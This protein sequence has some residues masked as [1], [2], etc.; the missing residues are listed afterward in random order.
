MGLNSSLQIGRS[1]L[2]VSQVA[3]QVTGNNFANASTPGYSRQ[4]V[5]LAPNI[6][7]RQGGYFLG[8]GVGIQGITR[9]V[10][11]ALQA[12][13][14]S[15]LSQE[16]FAATVSQMLSNVESTLNE[17]TDND[18]SSEFG[19]FF[20]AWSQLA[21][22]PDQGGRRSIVIQQ[23]RT[24]AASI[25]SL[26]S[27]LTQLRTQ[28]DNQLSATVQTADSLLSRIA[29]LNA[30][31][32]NAEGGSST[33]N[34]LRD[35]RD[36]LVQELSRLMDVSTVEQPSGTL[37]VLVGSTPVVL[38]GVSRG[39]E[40]QRQ[41]VNGEVRVS[42]NLKSDSTRLDVASGSIGGLLDQRTSSIDSTINS[43]DTIASQLIF[44]VNRLHS[45]GYPKTGFTSL[46]GTQR[47]PGADVTR[48]LNDPANQTFA[49]L[50]FRAVNGGFLVTVTNNVTGAS[51]T[52]RID[53][54]LDGLNSSGAPGFGDDSSVAS[55]AAAINALSNIS[56][57][58][59]P[60]GTLRIDSD[61]GYTFGLSEDSSGVLAVLGVNTYFTGT[62]ASNIGLREALVADPG[63]LAAGQIV[64]GQPT[65]N[66]AALAILG[67]RD[68]SIAALGGRSITAA[69]LD[70]AQDVGGRSASAA[71]RADAT[72]LVR[73]SLDAQRAAISGVS[74]DEESINLLNYQRQYQGAARFIS[75]IDQMTQTLLSLVG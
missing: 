62:N 75:V 15:G 11:S 25:R 8:R 48:A 43:L 66:G 74:I 1:A 26:R 28:L 51:E 20:D 13:L 42:V 5:G 14:W 55:I 18:L 68:Q 58:V 21:N 52:T 17:L 49:G 46:T 54:D 23:G 41:T 39:I 50:P 33:A 30:A 24:L 2:T 60:D 22:S 16:S 53:V 67:L 56:A 65:D 61:E 3:L 34:G 73:E 12:R 63:L 6:D 59:N 47:V 70:T 32:V 72:K 4:L 40:L 44:N 57:S 31:I 7:A 64:A 38:A 71:N 37:D 27:D 35:Q 69:W 19:R 9:Q 45:T 10:D 36:T 29:D